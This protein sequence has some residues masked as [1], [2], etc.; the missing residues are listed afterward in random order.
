MVYHEIVLM[1]EGTLRKKR[2]ETVRTKK[3][4]EKVIMS[5]WC[6]IIV[7]IVITSAT[8]QFRTT[9]LLLIIRPSICSSIYSGTSAVTKEG[10]SQKF[11]F[12]RDIRC[13]L[14]A[15]ASARADQ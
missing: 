1:T 8:G 3:S 5:P 13:M 4:H 12:S 11:E 9:V 7:H 10:V 2:F 6:C 15:W 14:R